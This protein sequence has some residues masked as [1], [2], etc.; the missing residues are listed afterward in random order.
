MLVRFCAVAIFATRLLEPAGS[1]KQQLSFVSTIE[2]SSG[3]CG[4]CRFN[5]NSNRHNY[6]RFHE[7]SSCSKSSVDATFISDNFD[8]YS[9]N[10]EGG[11]VHNKV[12]HI[13]FLDQS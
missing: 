4:S 8:N 11:C 1:F 3:V 2:S 7:V 9:S 6:Q 5:Q 10:F 12:N 13:R